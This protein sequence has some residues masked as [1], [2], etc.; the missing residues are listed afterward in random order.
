MNVLVSEVGRRRLTAIFL[1]TVV[2]SGARAEVPAAAKS[3]VIGAA[4]E[5]RQ[6]AVAG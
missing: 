5:R 2:L 4:N 6:P 3:M 1:A